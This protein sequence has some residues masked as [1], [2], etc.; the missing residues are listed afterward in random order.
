MDKKVS[1]SF[2]DILNSNDLSAKDIG[3]ILSNLLNKEFSYLLKFRNLSEFTSNQ[4]PLNFIDN[5]D[6]KKVIEC[7][8]ASVILR[9]IEKGNM[10]IFD[11]LIQKT[12]NTDKDL[13]KLMTEAAK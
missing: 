11:I 5:L 7:Y 10:G 3:L 12:E 1:R 6:N 9:S 2:V 4:Q 8:I 13:Y